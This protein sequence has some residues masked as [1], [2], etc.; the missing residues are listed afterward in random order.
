MDK[1]LEQLLYNTVTRIDFN[2]FS[3]Y[4]NN[5]NI[6]SVI[7]NNIDKNKGLLSFRDKDSVVENI[8]NVE[9]IK[10][11]LE[12]IDT[13]LNESNINSNK[14]IINYDY[15][16]IIVEVNIKNSFFTISNL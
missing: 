2:N 14:K 13:I 1:E 6:E 4:I 16:K 3:P 15:K 12:K 11:G 5:L 9:D 7:S 10:E 8:C